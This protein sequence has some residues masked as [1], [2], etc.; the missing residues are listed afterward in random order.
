MTQTKQ[1]A[2]PPILSPEIYQAIAVNA[3]KNPAAKLIAIHVPVANA[4]VAGKAKDGAIE[5]WT[6]V[7][8]M[9]E[10]ATRVFLADEIERGNATEDEI[11]FLK[12][13]EVATENLKLN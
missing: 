5:L 1:H 3:E 2:R 11:V 13:A 10:D 4:T 8:P 7:A 12:M 6:V 9:S